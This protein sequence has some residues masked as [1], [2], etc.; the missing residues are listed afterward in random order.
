MGGNSPQ[1]LVNRTCLDIQR[2]RGRPRAAR[3]RRGVAHADGRP[4]GGRRARLDGA[5]RRRARGAAVDPRGADVVARRAGPRRGDAGAG[6]PAVRAGAPRRCSAATSTSTSSPSPSC[7]RGSARWPRPTRTR[8]SSRR[9]RAEEI[10]TP[11]PDNRMIGFPYTKRMNSNNA[12]EQGAALILCSAE[13]AEAL[14]VPRDRWV[15][16]HSGTDAHDHYFVSE[17][18]DLGRSPAI[19]VAGRACAR[20]RR[21]RRRRPRPRRPLLLL[22]V[23]GADRR[24]RA[25]PRPRPPAHGHRRPVLRRRAVEQLRDARDRRRW[26][27]CCATTRAARPV[28]ANGGFITKHAFGV[29]CTEP[30]ATPFRHADPQAEVDALPPRELCEEPDGEVT[31]EAWTVMHDREGD[32]E[33]GI[34]VGCST[35][36]AAPWHH[37]GRRPA[38]GAGHRGAG[39]PPRPTSRPTAPTDAAVAAGRYWRSRFSAARR[40]RSFDDLPRATGHLLEELLERG[41]VEGEQPHRRLGDHA[42]VARLVAD[43]R[44]LADDRCRADRGDVLAA[45]YT[46]AWP[47][48]MKK[49]SVPTS[50][51]SMRTAPAS[52]S[53]AR[54]ARRSWRRRP[55]A[56]WRTAAG[57]AGPRAPD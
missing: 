31:I 8:G 27:A 56:R 50:P 23:G 2:G 6:V 22:P 32:P 41:D 40:S 28:T 20:A 49:H 18:D 19:R 9:T 14:G 24:Q 5:G 46:P 55:R 30:P 42:G 29:Y 4:V 53:T 34:V 35:T 3:R 48:I 1:S 37:P 10:R 33:N 25:R 15:F 52:A 47:S 57:G 43:E 7:G 44:H 21:R 38:E 45:E 17:R 54:R 12:V 26:P 39:R 51:W 11:S 36:A 13:R 16:P